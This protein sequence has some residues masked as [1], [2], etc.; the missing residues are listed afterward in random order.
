[1]FIFIC[2]RASGSHSLHI[3]W[4]GS[5]WNICWRG[6]QRCN[7]YT[8]ILSQVSLIVSIRLLV[9]S[10]E[11]KSLVKLSSYKYFLPFRITVCNPQA[12]IVLTSYSHCIAFMHTHTHTLSFRWQFYQRCRRFSCWR[13]FASLSSHRR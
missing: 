4:V 9:D 2:E 3:V 12:F 10:N 8:L 1:L 7:R 13:Q 6:R 11:H 5:R